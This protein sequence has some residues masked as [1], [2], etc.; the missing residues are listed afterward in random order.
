MIVVI[1]Q[2]TQV[3]TLDKQTI[4][5]RSDR[6]VHEVLVIL[7]GHIIDNVKTLEVPDGLQDHEI[8]KWVRSVGKV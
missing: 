3:S 2:V 7:Q 5:V 6:S 1:I 4:W 8:T